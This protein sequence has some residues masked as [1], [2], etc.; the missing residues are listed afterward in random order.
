MPIH[1]RM[2][3]HQRPFYA[4]AEFVAPR[5]IQVEEILSLEA[6]V[7]DGGSRESIGGWGDLAASVDVG[8]RLAKGFAESIGGIG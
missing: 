6:K 5:Y 7:S 2:Q 8:G 1:M 3:L 4:V